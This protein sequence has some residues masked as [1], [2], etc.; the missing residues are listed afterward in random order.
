MKK[1]LYQLGGLLLTALTICSCK[2]EGLSP[3]TIVL[4]TGYIS[5]NVVPE[6]IRP[7]LTSYITINEGAHP[8]FVTGTYVMSPNVLVYSSDGQFDVG[9]KFGDDTFTLSNQNNY[10]IIRD[11]YRLQGGT[12]SSAKNIEICGNGS[13]FTLYFIEEG[14]SDQNNDGRDETYVKQSVIISGTI[15]SN[16]I[17]NIRRAFILL[18]KRDPYDKIMDVNE[19]RVFRD[20]DELASKR[21]TINYTPVKKTRDNDQTDGR[22]LVEYWSKK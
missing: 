5:S 19:F 6:D 10:G 9:D 13:D 2:Y 15:T 22:E 4:P 7:R 21:S 8:P 17:K 16:G 11:F 3:E 12:T 14:N 18:E 20:G 1:V